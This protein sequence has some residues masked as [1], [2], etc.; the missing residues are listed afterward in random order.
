MRRLLLAAVPLVALALAASGCSFFIG[1]GARLF[2]K[3]AGA[4]GVRISRN[5]PYR[6][7]GNPKHRLDLYV[8]SAAASAAAR[9]DSS[10]RW[11]VV[12]FIHGGGWTSG[13]KDLSVGGFEPYANMA[14]LLSSQGIGVA[15]VGYRLIDAGAKGEGRPASS[16]TPDGQVEDVAAAT[17][18]V[19]A[20]AARYGAD[21]ER[22][23]VMGHSAGGQLA[24]RL[25]LDPT[26]L[27]A[28]GAPDGSVCG[29][30]MVSGAALD[31]TDVPSIQGDYRYFAARFAPPGT[32]VAEAMPPTPAAWQRDASPATYATAAAP[33][34]RFFTAS[35]EERTFRM[36]AERLRAALASVGV[37]TPPVGTFGAPA[38]SAGALTMSRP[39]RIVG[40]ETA[41]FVRET[42]CR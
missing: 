20:N 18:W 22:L 14:R 36:Q 17:A 23:F 25:A 32:V 42:V 7:G 3:T 35:G 39:G 38:H 30:V 19:R 31:L 10:A 9:G 8:P 6:T 2:S 21:V 11:P 26:W 16:V 29:A 34:F 4:E 5:I 27:R 1:A 28:A 12:V 40:R 13:D 37:E 15:L 33:P 41:A 24:A